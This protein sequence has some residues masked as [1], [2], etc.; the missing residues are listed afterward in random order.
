MQ[1]V[2]EQAD[3][4]AAAVA[5]ADMALAH[6]VEIDTEV[7]QQEVRACIV[8]ELGVLCTSAAAV[9]ARG[10]DA[11][12][13]ADAQTVC[14]DQWAASCHHQS[15]PYDM[16]VSGARNGRS[17]VE[18]EVP[19]VEAVESTGQGEQNIWVAL[20]GDCTPEEDAH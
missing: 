11:T 9:P 15:S 3:G 7:R 10:A 18:D 5:L 1:K 2:G 13:A 19:T 6:S 16:K 17:V 20:P 14:D 8:A 4:I 12:S